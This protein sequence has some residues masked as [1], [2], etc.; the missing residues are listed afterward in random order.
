MKGSAEASSELAHATANIA[1]ENVNGEGR[2]SKL[3]DDVVDRDAAEVLDNLLTEVVNG[4]G[5]SAREDRVPVVP[6]DDTEELP[7]RPPLASGPIS[8]EAQVFSNVR[9][10]PYRVHDDGESD[11]SSSSSSSSSEDESPARVCRAPK[12]AVEDEDAELEDAEDEVARPA[13]KRK[14]APG[15]AAEN[16]RFKSPG[17]KTPG[18]LDIEDLPP[19]EDLRIT[20][21]Q[22]D[23]R[24]AGVVFSAVEQL[25]VVESAP[26]QPVLD[27]DSV[28]FLAGGKPLGQVFDVFGPVSS[29]FYV[30]RF[31]SA[32]ELAEKHIGKGTQVFYAPLHADVT[33]YVLESEVRKMRGSDASWEN[34]NE[35]PPEHLDFSDDEQE[36]EMQ[37]RRR[38]KHPATTGAATSNGNANAN[39]TS[40]GRTT[41]ASRNAWSRPGPSTNG[42]AQQPNPRYC[43]P[44]SGAGAGPG[45]GPSNHP[46][47]HPMPYSPAMGGFPMLSPGGEPPR[48]SGV[49]MW[50]R[51]RPP[52][53]PPPSWQWGP[54]TWHGGSPQQQHQQL[55]CNIW[56]TPPPLPPAGSRPWQESWPR[57]AAMSPMPPPNH[58]CQPGSPGGASTLAT[59]P[60]HVYDPVPDLQRILSTPPPPPL[61]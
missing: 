37:K 22:E 12:P 53:P 17:M 1:M 15:R 34:N 13:P 38:G 14:G 60:S 52:P 25:L 56:S 29:P 49:P 24:R 8:C 61:L 11:S 26:G 46:S 40:A 54:P 43:A 35:P 33:I 3:V 30:V 41:P 31:N 39:E 51:Y 21:P 18:E 9:L 47:R 10:V 44:P 16:R 4:G 58:G 23:L 28:L 36:R 32:E 57:P 45:R 19:I 6:G 48:F 59:S 50:P 27:L 20:V 7:P 5:D 55:L 2:L 42:N